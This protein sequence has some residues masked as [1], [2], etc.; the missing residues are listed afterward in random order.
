M[1]RLQR[2]AEPCSRPGLDSVESETTFAIGRCAAE[3]MEVRID[4][5]LLQIVGMIITSVGV[6]LPDFHH[7]VIDRRAI[8]VQYASHDNDPLAAGLAPGQ[9]FI[10]RSHQR[11]L[12]EWTDS[13]RWRLLRDHFNSA[14]EL[15]C[16][17]ATRSR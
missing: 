16:G 11:W 12:E 5:L 7:C 17:R 15:R 3:P 4:Q 2:V 6:R 10:C 14:S 13:L 8:A 9:R 1:R